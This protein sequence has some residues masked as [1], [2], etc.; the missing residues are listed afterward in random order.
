MVFQKFTVSISERSMKLTDVSS[1]C[2][3]WPWE[4]YQDFISLCSDLQTTLIS[5]CWTMQSGASWR[6]ASTACKSVTSTTSLSNS[7]IN[8]P[9]YTIRYQ[10]CSYSVASSF[11]C[12]CEGGQMTFWTLFMTIDTVSHC[13][14]GDNWTC[15]PCCHG[16]VFFV[17]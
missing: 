2:S 17:V 6:S 13:F 3:P 10:C 16:N 1:N 9:D 7:W 4:D 12:V 15:S 14:I 11:E 8:G 5:S